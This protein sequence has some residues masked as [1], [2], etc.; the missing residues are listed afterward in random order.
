MLNKFIAGALVAS[1]LA[2]GGCAGPFNGLSREA[3]PM[4]VTWRNPD[5]GPMTEAQYREVVRHANF[6]REVAH[7]QL[8]G[9]VEASATSGVAYGAAGALGVGGGSKA[10]GVGSF[11]TMGTYGGIAGAGNGVVAGLQSKSAA[12]VTVVGYCV[13]A[14]ISDPKTKSKIGPGVHAVGAYVRS[15]NTSKVPSWVKPGQPFE[16]DEERG[17]STEGAPTPPPPPQ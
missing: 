2:M 5:Y 12:N 15:R 4:V 8:S 9:P 7:Q 11:G 17:A 14:N 3:M 6:C 16:A 10:A 1:S 13:N